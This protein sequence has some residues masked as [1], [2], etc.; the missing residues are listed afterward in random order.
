MPRWAY[1]ASAILV[2]P[3]S[4]KQA[5]GFP[6]RYEPPAQWFNYLLHFSL[7]WADHLRGPGWGAWTR[8]DHGATDFTAVSGLAVDIDDARAR[9]QRVR[10]AIVGTQSG[11]A[12]H[13]ITSKNGRG[14]T[15]R[16][17]PTSSTA[18]Y[19]IACLGDTWYTWGTVSSSTAVWS[20]PA[21]TGSNNSAVRTGTAGHWSSI[22]ALAGLTVCGIVSNGVADY[23]ALTRVGAGQYGIVASANG[24]TSWTYSAGTVWTNGSDQATG[25]VYD[26]SRQ[27]FLVVSMLG[28][29]KR[30]GAS[31][32]WLTS[33]TTLGNLSGIPTDARVHLR[34]GGPE[35]ERTLLAWASYREDGT[36]SLSASLLWRSTDGGTTWSAITLPSAMSASGGAAIVTDIQHVDGTWVATTSAAPYLW[37]SDDDGQNWERLPLPIAE[38]S[39]W[40]LSRAIYADGQILATGLTWTVT[41]TRASATSPGTWTSREPTYLADAGYL[42]GRRIATTA[43]TSGQVYTWNSGTAQW[44]PTSASAFTVT[45]TRGDLIVRGASADQRLAIGAAARYLRSDGTDPSWSQ[46]LAADL[47]GAPWSSVLAPAEVETN[48]ATT[49]TLASIATAA[50]R[51]YAVEVTVVS[52][53]S[54]AAVVAWKLLATVHSDGGGTLTLND[55]LIH[56]PTDAGAS[57]M[58]ATVDVSGSSIRVRVT[59]LGGTS[60]SWS[61]AGTVLALEN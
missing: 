48:D 16:S 9:D 29:V 15:D 45:T 51:S 21:D 57:G 38:E 61:V 18:L 60:V 11:P 36:T 52:T 14:W 5:D 13:V 31:G 33:T 40:V 43:P 35:D 42:R 28:E 26:D 3:T 39:S 22:A 27:R 37:R 1:S 34:V 8:E 10:Y 53:R 23:L 2:E 32:A 4:D 59:G 24:G 17:A 55:V 25:I 50:S 44:E 30:L 54:P 49:T 56:G 47:T 19:G 20:T 6:S 7:A 41:S 58:A 46:L 12:T